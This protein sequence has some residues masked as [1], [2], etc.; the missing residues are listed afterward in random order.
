VGLLD[1]VYHRQD[2][3]KLVWPRIESAAGYG[4][5]VL[6]SAAFTQGLVSRGVI[7]LGMG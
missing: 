7:S 6:A 5:K 3:I 4:V 1:G 2:D